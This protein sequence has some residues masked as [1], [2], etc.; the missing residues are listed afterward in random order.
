[1]AVLDQE[2]GAIESRLT[3]RDLKLA[4]EFYQILNSH[5][6]SLEATATAEAT[7]ETEIEGIME[8]EMSFYGEGFGAIPKNLDELVDLLGI[9][10]TSTTT[11]FRDAQPFPAFATEDMWPI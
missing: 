4:Q 9:S 11:S 6:T 8:E 3:N 2:E 7:A 1:M 10:E 5:T